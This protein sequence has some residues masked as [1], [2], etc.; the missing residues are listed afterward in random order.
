MT[1]ADVKSVATV[2][3]TAA[4]G[5]EP[6][7][8]A[9]SSSSGNNLQLV[10]NSEPEMTGMELD[11]VVQQQT[12]LLYSLQQVEITHGQFNFIPNMEFWTCG[13]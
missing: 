11:D 1:I 9:T 6:Q 5:A 12:A 10:E 4:V 7:S 13:F 8:T 2:V 3:S